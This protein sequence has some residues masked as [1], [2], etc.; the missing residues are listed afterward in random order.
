MAIR[1]VFH[2]INAL[3]EWELQD[4]ASRPFLGRADM[5]GRGKLVYDLPYR[6]VVKLIEEHYQIKL[7]DLPGFAE[8]Q[9]VRESVNAFKHRKG[10]KDFRKDDS[11]R[12]GD[13]FEPTRQTAY[14]AID[15]A[16]ALLEALK[17]ATTR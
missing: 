17:N 3:V 16:V 10:F 9:C 5:P 15:A 4:L 8:I 12:I 7:S 14:Q 1:A 13:R 6:D 2:E 11:S